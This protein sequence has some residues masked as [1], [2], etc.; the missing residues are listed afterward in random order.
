MP[1]AHAVSPLARALGSLG[2][3]KMSRLGLALL[4]AS[5]QAVAQEYEFNVPAQRLDAAL[6]ALGRQAG[7]QVLYNPSDL[8]GLR[9]RSVS[10][11]L[12]LEQA[13]SQL[14]DGA[15][16]IGFELQ[17][18][19]LI[20]RLQD[21]SSVISLDSMVVSGLALNPTTENSGSYASPAV[22]IGKGNKSIKEIPQSVTVVTQ[23]RMQDQ[24]M[25]T[26]S[27]VLANAPGVTSIPM[28]GTGEQYY[29][30]GFFIEN[31]QYDGVPLERQSYARG[32]DFSGQT[33]I[34]DRVEIL[35]GAQGLLEG[36]GNPSGSVNFVRKR[37]TAENQVRLTAKAGSWDH[38]GTQADISGPIDEQGRLRG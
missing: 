32:S 33:A 4:L 5:A 26:V 10:G 34:F 36:G 12:E 19:T 7:L 31:F 37:P 3:N 16:G 35:R 20:L 23:K 27:D 18:K 9:S 21:S 13:I 38:Y 6:Q 11:K 25:S 1:T 8:S 28:F 17:G 14:L 29:S 30:R 22:S 24:N 2:A 15:N